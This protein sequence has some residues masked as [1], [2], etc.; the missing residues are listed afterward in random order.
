MEI[1]KDIP[2]NLIPAELWKAFT[3]I[4]IALI[5]FIM[6]KNLS[7]MREERKEFRDQLLKLV[8]KRRGSRR[9]D[10]RNRGGWKNCKV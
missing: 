4:L 3:L 8:I 9:K 1:I 10:R 7:E 6:K 5:A 2:T